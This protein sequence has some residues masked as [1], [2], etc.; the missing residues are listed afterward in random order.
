MTSGHAQIQFGAN[1]L[2]LAGVHALQRSGNGL[3]GLVRA[4]VNLAADIANQSDKSKLTISNVDA[5]VS[6]QSLRIRG[7]DAGGLSASVHTV[8]GNVVYQAAS[9]FAGS[10][11]KVEG[12]TALATGY[13]T[14]ATAAIS[15]LSVGKTLV[16]ANENGGRC[17][18]LSPPTRRSMARLTHR[19]PP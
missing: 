11:V 18:A 4:R 13:Y 12:R 6:A 19:M 16:L 3:A 14:T 1:S 8:N 10:N 5:D 7:E 2:Q 17:Q 9:N 15:N